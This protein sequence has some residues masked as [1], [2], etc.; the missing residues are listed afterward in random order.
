M[1]KTEAQQRQLDS[2]LGGAGAQFRPAFNRSSGG[3]YSAPGRSVVSYDRSKPAPRNGGLF[4]GLFRDF[5]DGGGLG[6]SGD[7]FQ[8][9]LYSGL[10]NLLGVEPMSSLQAP[11]SSPAPTPRPA[12]RPAMAPVPVVEQSPVAVPPSPVGGA[13]LLGSMGAG[14]SNATGVLGFGSGV[15]AMAPPNV[16][17]FAQQPTEP[18]A[19]PTFRPDA[20]YGL[21]PGPSRPPQDPTTQAPAMVDQEIPGLGLAFRSLETRQDVDDTIRNTRASGMTGP[22]TPEPFDVPTSEPRQDVLG[23]LLGQSPL[24]FGDQPVRMSTRGMDP[25]ADLGELGAPVDFPM[26]YNEHARNVYGRTGDPMARQDPFTTSVVVDALSSMGFEDAKMW[27]A[28]RGPHESNHHGA[29]YDIDV[30]GMP[31][32]QRVE[33]VKRLSERGATGIGFGDG[34][35]HV[36]TRGDVPRTWYYDRG[37]DVSYVPENKRYAKE[38][39]DAHMAGRFNRQDPQASIRPAPRPGTPRGLI[40]E[41]EAPP[42]GLL[43]DLS[44]PIEDV[45]MSAKNAPASMTELNIPREMGAQRDRAVLSAVQQGNVSPMSL[46]TSPVTVDGR[47]TQLPEG[48]EKVVFDVGN[49]PVML[50]NEGV[51]YPASFDGGPMVA[52]ALGGAAPTRVIVDAGMDQGRRVTMP[53]QKPGPG[54]TSMEAAERQSEAIRDKLN[55]LTFFNKEILADGT[56]YGGVR[57]GKRVWQTRPSRGGHSGDYADY[58]H[59]VRVVRTATVYPENGEPYQVPVS[60]LYEDPAFARALGL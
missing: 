30:R 20:P 18:V 55:G 42:A 39:M 50:G 11:S 41:P 35:I 53:T 33:L 28:Y 47:Y 16:R 60:E 21:A 38:V 17:Q 45:S 26:S 23:G 31:P 6:Q 27:S 43:G 12:P 2:Y 44:R 15:P 25:T 48:V 40:A 7:K 13:G 51:L 8:G 24:T 32:E 10:L 5:F 59:G 49:A 54:M 1:P 36:D 46:E 29:A 14:A 57:D 58:S 22:A 3:H 34:T 4:G 19:T 37:N 9:G 56:F 52:A